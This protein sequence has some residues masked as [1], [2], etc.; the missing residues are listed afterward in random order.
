MRYR[1]YFLISIL[2]V[3]ITAGC[4][5][6]QTSS[7]TTTSPAPK[8]SDASTPANLQHVEVQLDEWT[9]KLSPSTVNAGQVHFMIQNA[10]DIAHAFEIKG[11]GID[12]KTPN[13]SPK[14]SATLLVTLKSG[15]YDTFCPID[16]HKA[17]GMDATLTVK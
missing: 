9:V 10:G 13:I 8:P 2:I 6:P 5:R 11:Q 7:P 12:Q 14:Q 3:A 17:K 16:G 4:Q 15:D 1:V